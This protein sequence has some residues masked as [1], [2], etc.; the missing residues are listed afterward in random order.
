MNILLVR[1]HGLYFRSTGRKVEDPELLEA[2]RLTIINNLLKYHPV[3][4]RHSYLCILIFLSVDLYGK[5]LFACFELSIRK[6]VPNWPWEQHLVLIHRCKRHGFSVPFILIMNRKFSIILKI[7]FLV[8]LLHNQ[9]DVDI[10]TH[11]YI[12][13]DG[14]DRRYIML[15]IQYPSSHVLF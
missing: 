6:P 7:E 11:I 5:Q 12:Y 9:V 8:P 13:D 4:Y 10:A 1:W 14:P 2:I 15:L 3:I